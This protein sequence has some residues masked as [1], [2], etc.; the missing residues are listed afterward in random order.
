MLVFD[1]AQFF[2]S[3]NHQLLPLILNKASFNPKVSTFFQNYL[4]GRKTKYLWKSFFSLF[5]NVDVRVGQGSALS[6]IL[7]SLYL[8][9]ILHILKKE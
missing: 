8:S 4:V 7:L 6:S 1:I 5:F 3:L 2:P 9:P